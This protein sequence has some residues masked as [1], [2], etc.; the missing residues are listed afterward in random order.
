MAE[1]STVQ[2][3]RAAKS[4]AAASELHYATDLAQRELT[5]QHKQAADQ[6]QKR[7]KL[8]LLS[9]HARRSYNRE[10]VLVMDAEMRL[11]GIPLSRIYSQTGLRA[12][13]LGHSRHEVGSEEHEAHEIRDGT[14][15]RVC[16]VVL[17]QEAYCSRFV[18]HVCQDQ[19]PKG[20]AACAFLSHLGIRGTFE[21]DPIHR[22]HND[23]AVAVQR[24]GMAPLRALL[25]RVLSVRSGPFRSQSHQG[26]VKQ[27]TQ[28]LRSASAHMSPLWQVFY[29][30]VVNERRTPSSIE[31]GEPSHL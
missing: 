3:D 17:T 2:H 14:N 7:R 8:N 24:S 16:G 12:V 25:R 13:P 20:L 31:Y 28:L 21:F 9:D 19:G 15:N 4:A 6:K 30:S 27:C 26:L 29:P 22:L 10:H 11:A 18:W 5:T 1:A 23:W